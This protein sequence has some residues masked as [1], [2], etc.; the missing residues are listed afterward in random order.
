MA[1]PPYV[2]VR[3]IHLSAGTEYLFVR[4][5]KTTGIF[6]FSK[7]LQ[8]ADVFQ[9]ISNIVECLKSA[10]PHIKAHSSIDVDDD[11]FYFHAA[12]IAGSVGYMTLQSITL[13]EAKIIEI[14]QS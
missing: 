8:S 14:M 1:M 13:D 5:D 7:L 4:L 3:L 9:S 10:L 6:Y 2:L 12:P 11:N